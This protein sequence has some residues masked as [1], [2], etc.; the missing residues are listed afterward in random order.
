VEVGKNRSFDSW[1]RK[2]G[3]YYFRSR[4]GKIR[5]GKNWSFDSWALASIAHVM[6]IKDSGV[7]PQSCDNSYLCYCP[8]HVHH[9]GLLNLGVAMMESKVM[10]SGLFIDLGIGMRFQLG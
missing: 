10:D 1:I 2:L 6:N 3:K 4:L 5:L 7:G 8:L 9:F